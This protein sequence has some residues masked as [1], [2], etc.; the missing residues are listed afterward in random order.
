MLPNWLPLR[1]LPAAC[2]AGLLV[3]ASASADC[4]CGTRAIGVSTGPIP[5]GYGSPAPVVLG[6]T[7]GGLA[8]TPPPPA[9]LSPGPDSALIGDPVVASVG[10]VNRFGVAPPP[11]TLSRTFQLRSTLVD[12]DKHPRIGVVDVFLPENVDVT[13]RGMKSQ[14]TGKV[15]RLETKEPLLPGVPHIYAI[16]AERKSPTGDVVSTDVRWVRLIMGRIVDLRF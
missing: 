13:A 6:P 14:W 7:T 5:D 9:E 3:A 16:K 2:A 8:V 12:D 10:D 15:W 11:G 4:K 1:R